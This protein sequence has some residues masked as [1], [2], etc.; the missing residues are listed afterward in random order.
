MTTLTQKDLENFWI[1]CYLS[2]STDLENAAIDRAYLDFNRTLHGIGKEQS[3]DKLNDLKS[4]MKKIVLELLTMT[5]KNQ[6]DFDRWHETKC[7]ELVKAFQDISNHPLYIGQAQKWINMTLKYLFAL[8]ENRIKGISRNYEYFHFPI[9]N[10]I[11][12]KLVKRGIP[13]IDIP[14]SRINNYGKYLKYQCLVREKFAG[15]I[16]IEVEFRLFNE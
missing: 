16:P 4:V 5:F 8:G 14:W 6:D 12:E 2:P 15:Q 1:R 11:Q 3:D 10:I 7:A 9:D 13:K